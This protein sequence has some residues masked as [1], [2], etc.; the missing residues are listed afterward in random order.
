MIFPH[1]CPCLNIIL[2][3][4]TLRRTY[5]RL[6]A[7]SAQL[8]R[9]NMFLQANPVME[10]LDLDD[11]CFSVG[12]D[13]PDVGVKRARKHDSEVP[14]FVLAAII[15]C[16]DGRW[17]SEL[18]S[19]KSMNEH[20]C[21]ISERGC[22]LK[23]ISMDAA[24]RRSSVPF[25]GH[26]NVANIISKDDFTSV[27]DEERLARVHGV[28]AAHSTFVGVAVMQAWEILGHAESENSEEAADDH[29]EDLYFREHFG[30]MKTLFCHSLSSRTKIRLTVEKAKFLFIGHR[31][32]RSAFVR[33][34][35][36]FA[37]PTHDNK[38]PFP[39]LS[40]ES[41]VID[42]TSFQPFESIKLWC[43]QMATEFKLLNNSNSMVIWNLCPFLA[44]HVA[45]GSWHVDVTPVSKASCCKKLQSIPSECLPSRRT[46]TKLRKQFSDTFP[47]PPIIPS[48]SQ[49]KVVVQQSKVQ[50]NGYIKTYSPQHR[51]NG[52]LAVGSKV[53]CN[54]RKGFK[55]DLRSNSKRYA[56]FLLGDSQEADSFVSEREE[57]GL[58]Y[59]ASNTLRRDRRTLD[60]VS[61]LVARERNHSTPSF[62]Y[63]CY[64]A[65]PQRSGVEVFATFQR[66]I[67][68]RF[69]AI[70]LEGFYHEI[71]SD[72]FKLR[73]L[74][75]S[76]LGYTKA[77]MFDK[78]QC[79]LHEL[80]LEH[81]PTKEDMR[82]MEL[83][84]RHVSSDM[85]TEFGVGDN[86]EFID[87]FFARLHKVK[88]PRDPV[89]A[90]K[91]NYMFPLAIKSPGIQHIIDWVIKQLLQKL[92]F[93]DEFE[94][95]A[96]T[97]L[98]FV[99][100]SGH[101][102]K[103]VNLIDSLNNLDGQRKVQLKATLTKSV[104]DFAK[105]RWHTLADACRALLRIREVCEVCFADLNDVQRNFVFREKNIG[106]KLHSII[107]SKTIW[108]QATALKLL[109]KPLIKFSSWL[110][111]CKCHEQELLAGKHV[112]CH[113]KGIR[114]REISSQ[115]ATV[116]KE[117]EDVRK[118]IHITH[119][120][121]F[122]QVPIA[123]LILAATT[124]HGELSLKMRWVDDPPF[125]I[126]KVLCAPTSTF[127]V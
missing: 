19:Q 35:Q 44:C 9:V 99:H 2:T 54:D 28:G 14:R 57:A 32:V 92:S 119:S 86:V 53:I 106:L 24:R 122:P 62:L 116:L 110:R 13:H 97:V 34:T 96:K 104:Y 56:Q 123:D 43:D 39:I 20:V 66:S 77:G 11:E 85:G 59:P 51:L 79:T 111:A 63:L 67:E 31:F 101:R 21:A 8:L 115:V 90:Q 5:C 109:T 3:S 126:W 83:Q 7:A 68:K 48:Q 98:Q 65:S 30:S 49:A 81:G 50:M 91:L 17:S 61:M 16:P 73:L 80:W 42:N 88:T 18:Q 100:S 26:E 37:V 118:A 55:E 121:S 127:Q 84:V 72:M 93:W 23:S 124:S 6:L 12:A 102:D 94:K 70:P 82:R 64:D 58:E 74:P 41:V 120:L 22:L 15:S 87:E 69:L 10:H 78:S 103:M 45:N 40:M 47:S 52:L 95:S 107:K 112:D 113:W 25:D 1:I 36:A 114:A 4:W 75:I 29:D 105:W 27:S 46:L 38:F 89:R 108:P 125:T 76:C 60:I 71:S 117:I 33:D